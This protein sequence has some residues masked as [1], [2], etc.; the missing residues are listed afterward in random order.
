MNCQRNYP[1]YTGWQKDFATR[2]FEIIGIHTPEFPQEREVD[3][4]REQV[5]KANFKFPVVIDNDSKNW[6]TWGNSMWPSV[7]L[8]DKHGNIRYWWY[9]EL[10]W[11]GARGDQIMRRRI[12]ELLAE[13]Y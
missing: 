4:I 10:N 9:G 8:I 11:Q 12:E 2:D 5:A 13:S 1:W 3:R 7:Y 6:N